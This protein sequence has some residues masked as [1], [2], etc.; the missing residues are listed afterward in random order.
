MIDQRLFTFL[1]ICKT[2][3]FTR[4]AELL[5]MTQP[6]VTKH[7]KFLEAYYGAPLFIRNGRLMELTEEG[8][9]LFDYTK[10]IEAQTLLME[11][12]IKNSFDIERHYNIGATLTIGEFVLPCILGKYKVLSPHTDIIMQVHNTETITKKLWNG[13]IDLGLV[14]G[15]FD[16]SKYKCRL[17]RSDELVFAASPQSSF[18]GRSEVGIDEILKSK[19]ILR[20]EGSGTRKVLEDKLIALGYDLTHLKPYMEIGSLGAIKSLVEM[21]LGC[22]IISKTAVQK[23]L[24]SGSL[25]VIP[26]KGI[27]ILREFNF[28][29]HKESPAELV[30]SF[31]EFSIRSVDQPN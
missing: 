15:P 2:R 14:E 23:E 29:Y 5:H 11:R 19:L 4:A 20:E 8:K 12:K 6:A 16:K 13:E 10:D 1:T 26:I 25:I 3:N 18:S 28:I 24:A 27:R 21:N 31:I 9:I 7:I 17:L 30:N 22:T